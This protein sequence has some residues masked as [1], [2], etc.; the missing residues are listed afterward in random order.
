MSPHDRELR[1]NMRGEDVGALIRELLILGHSIRRE[2]VSRQRLGADTGRAV[3]EF[4]ARHGL[5]VNGV[6][7]ARTASAINAAVDRQGEE[8]GR[9]SMYEQEI[10]RLL[11]L[12][13]GADLEGLAEEDLGLSSPREPGS[14]V[15][16]ADH[17]WKYVPVRRMVLLIEKSLKR[18]LQWAVFE[19][20]GERLWDQIRRNVGSFLHT[21]FRQGAF[22]GSTP[23]EAYVVE[24]GAGTTS[25][26]EIDRGLV[27]I[28]V[29]FAPLRPAEFV[30][31]KVQQRA[32]QSRSST[33]PSRKGAPAHRIERV[34]VRRSLSSDDTET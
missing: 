33:E 26:A 1:S 12:L 23:N 14:P 18:G 30:I 6:V 32:G 5:P 20:N 22:K 25:R 16:R 24:C 34:R 8:D 29:G 10:A 2:E 9:W 3:R 17:E 28:V 7:D 15:G 21:L 11:P 4:Q 31:L 13:E 27:N 19:P